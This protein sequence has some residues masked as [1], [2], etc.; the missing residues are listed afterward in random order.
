MKNTEETREL[1]GAVLIS[2]NG[3]RMVFAVV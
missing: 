1:P 2:C 3:G